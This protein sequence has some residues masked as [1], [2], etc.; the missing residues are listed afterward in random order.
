MKNDWVP[1]SP[2][3]PDDPKIL[4][5]QAEMKWSNMQ[6]WSSVVLVWFW[7]FRFEPDGDV[8]DLGAN[9]IALCQVLRISKKQAGVARRFFETMRK[10]G[11]IEQTTDDRLIIYEWDQRVGKMLIAKEHARMRQQRQRERNANVTRTSRDCHA[12]EETTRE[13]M[14]GDEMKREGEENQTSKKK[15][16]KRSFLPS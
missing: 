1:V 2:D 5:L 3:L 13:E 16:P 12:G 15:P 10:V 11:L 6:T 7:A 4:L 8:T 14:T 9:D